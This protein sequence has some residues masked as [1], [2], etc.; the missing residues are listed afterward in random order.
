MPTG[1]NAP[2]KKV[3]RTKKTTQPVLSG[4]VVPDTKIVKG[5]FQSIPGVE[6]LIKEAFT[7]FYDDKNL[8]RQKMKDLQH[9]DG[10]VEEFL[11]AYIILGYDLN[12]EKVHI[13]HAENSM[14]KDSL[15]EHM[16]T[17]L[18]SYLNK[19]NN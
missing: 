19:E 2:K 8:E 6:S 12:G 9:L 4:D 11:K 13:F 17:T 15:V 14:E 10:V 5:D 18:M 7:R 3:K 16:R 1:D